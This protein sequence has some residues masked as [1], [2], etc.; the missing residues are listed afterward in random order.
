MNDQVKDQSRSIRR[1]HVERLKNAR[2]RFWGRDLSGERKHLS[3]VVDTPC[4]CSCFM[5]GNPRRR[6]R[7][8]TIQERRHEAIVKEDFNPG[9]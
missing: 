8:K 2:R 7:K 4:P 5:C 3:M 6:W 9:L 1:H